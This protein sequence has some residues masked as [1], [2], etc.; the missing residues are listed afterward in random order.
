MRTRYRNVLTACFSF[1]I[2]LIVLM[3]GCNGSSSSSLPI[4]VALSFSDLPVLN[5][6]VQITATFTKNGSEI[7]KII[8]DVTYSIKLPD[9]LEKV[10]GNTEIID[11]FNPDSGFVMIATVKSV[12]TGDWDIEARADYYTQS[13]H[14]GG[15]THIYVSIKDGNAS[16]SD[17]PIYPTF[18]GNTLTVTQ[19][20][21]ATSNIPSSSPPVYSDD[22]FWYKPFQDLAI[23]ADCIIVANVIAAKAERAKPEDIY[24]HWVYTT[25]TLTVEKL[26]KG[27]PDIKEVF[28]RE[29]GGTI[30]DEM[31]YLKVPWMQVAFTLNEKALACLKKEDNGYYSVLNWGIPW[32]QESDGYKYEMTMGNGERMTLEKLLGII[33]QTMLANNIPVALPPSEFP[34]IPMVTT[35]RFSPDPSPNDVP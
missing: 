29:P 15:N 23:Q 9:G 27:D 11:D 26:I 7:K 10:S 28:I 24:P 6:P 16:I 8:H 20:S 18:H 5:R 2:F 19:S 33:I 22:I 13:S 30:N 1:L 34:P 35:F 31:G 14:L 17:R 21:A 4:K 12:K 25:F 32:A 3:P